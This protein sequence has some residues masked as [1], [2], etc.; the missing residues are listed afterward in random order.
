[1][2]NIGKK[3][4]NK[5]EAE[6]HFKGKTLKGEVVDT[7]DENPILKPFRN[8]PNVIVEDMESYEADEGDVLKVKIKSCEDRC[9]FGRTVEDKPENSPESYR[10]VFTFAGLEFSTDVDDED[11]AQDVKKLLGEIW[12]FSN[13]E[14]RRMR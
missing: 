12:D 7:S 2:S 8:A 5:Y 4:Y 3:F 1:M 10:V 11:T 14:I 13:L 9:M 6:K